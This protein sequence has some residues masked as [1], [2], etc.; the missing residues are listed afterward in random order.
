MQ[1]N[2]F[3]ARVEPPRRTETLPPPSDA[4][5]EAA[6]L[7][8]MMLEA[9]V[10]STGIA[11][12][13]GNLEVFYQPSNRYVFA[14]IMRLNE[15]SQ[16]ID[17]YTVVQ[18]LTKV[19]LLAKAGGMGAVAGLMER[20]NSA[21][22]MAAHCTTLVELFV[23][24]RIGQ[25]GYEFLGKAHN[26]MADP[27]EL[28]AEAQAAINSLHDSLQMRRA[29]T[30]QEMVVDVFA[31]TR[32]ALNSPGGVTGVPTGLTAVDIVSGGWQPTELVIIAARPGMGKTSFTLACAKH[33][34]RSGK[35]GQFFSLEMGALQL[36]KKVVASESG[37]STA[38]L[39]RALDM[40]AEEIDYL[41]KQMA[42]L[43]AGGLIVDDTPSI[44]IG[45]LRAKVSKAVAEDGVQI[46]YIDYLQL[47]SGDAK[48]GNR[49]QEI[50]TIS[51]GLKLIA[52]E[53]NI[54]VIALAQLS[55]NVE[56]R[57]GDKRPMLSDLRESGSIEQDAD[58]V[59]FLYRSEYYKVYQDENGNPT[60]NTTEV[61]FAKQRNGGLKSPVVKSDMRTGR[62]GDLPQDEPLLLDYTSPLR[63][64]IDNDADLPF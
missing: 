13:K 32:R 26:P 56:T 49:E 19:G 1:P 60:E 40:N 24:R 44:S 47:M 37:Y 35:Q 43:A 20:A 29:R 33:A 50:G 34:Q 17:V 28:L 10:V 36:A 6:V 52:K 53:N 5:M 38:K 22:N 41:E 18:Q 25:I 61:I 21:A 58:V 4:N 63:S 59:I 15:T 2:K 7:G 39:G 55:R 3:A 8:A 11:L 27:L 54:P 12:L 14:A 9:K 42:D 46:V 48:S 45:E 64:Q 57:G 62:Y 31:E 30:V 16:P 23:K 51:R